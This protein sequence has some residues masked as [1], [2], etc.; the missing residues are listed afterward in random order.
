MR[1]P[2]RVLNSLAMHSKNLSYRFERL[3]RLLFNEELFYVAYQRTYAK[4]GNM[5]KGSNDITI[6]QM[7]L[8]RIDNL[9]DSLKNESY[10]PN[11]SRRVYIPKKNGKMRPLGIPSYDDKLV[12]EVIR[13]ILEAV[14]EGSFE[15]SSH[16]FRPGRSCHTALKQIHKTFSGTKW[17]IEGDI[18]GFFDNINHDVI[19]RILKERISDDRFIRLI[20]KFLKAGYMEDWTFHKTYSGTPQGGIIS[21]ILANIILD[22]LDKYMKNAIS[23]FDKGRVR[24]RTTE[25]NKLTLTK[26]QAKKMLQT[27]KTEDERANLIETI[28]EAR[29]ETINT[30]YANEMDC[31]Y[32]R[33]KYV[34]YADDF[35]IGVTGSKEDAC[36][37][38]NKVKL[39]LESELALELSDEKTQVTHSEK[40]AHFL[41]YD[42]SIRKTNQAKRNVNGRLS[43]SLNKTV[44]LKIPAGTIRK[45]L[46]EYNAVEIKQHSGKEQWKPKS[47]TMLSNYDDLE[48]LSMYNSEIRGLYNYYSLALNSS[49]LNMFRHNM[50]YSL[51][52]TFAQKYRTSV[53]GICKKYKHSG[54]FTIEYQNKTGKTLKSQFYNGGFKRQMQATISSDIMPTSSLRVSGNSLVLRLKAN[55]CEKCGKEGE[56]EMHHIN[57]LKNLKGKAEWEK[58]MIARRRKTLALCHECH[59]MIH[60]GQ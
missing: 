44:A 17:F 43:R 25:Y 30:P 60:H 42:I 7:S 55:I 28:K 54:I 2:E 56:L 49:S 11:P 13:M 32:K 40:T 24:K 20:R 46:L 37:I 9:I 34:R 16:G 4:A 18:Q 48:I 31:G 50:E 10:Q 38:K 29:K 26:V 53:V 59:M 52:K 23:E 15:H 51:Y 45:K 47:R 39:F 14:Y 3:Y 6:D 8:S 27:A 12:Q 57:K 1:N 33:L 21:P 22:K 19:I 36:T 35:L 41:G 58:I 5:T